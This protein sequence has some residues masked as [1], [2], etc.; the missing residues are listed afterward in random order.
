MG[1]PDFRL[2]DFEEWITCHGHKILTVAGWGRPVR[3][4]A[5]QGSNIR[6]Q[7]GDLRWKGLRSPQR[8]PSLRPYD[9]AHSRY[10]SFPGDLS[11]LRFDPLVL[12]TETGH[13]ACRPYI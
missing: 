12:R 11:I 7:A 2:A 3:A 9:G 1:N 6:S 4:D 5:R 8:S 13:S 10:S